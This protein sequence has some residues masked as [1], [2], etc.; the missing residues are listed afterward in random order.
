MAQYR[1]ILEG[2]NIKYILFVSLDKQGALLE[3]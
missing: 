2:A 1:G 3:V